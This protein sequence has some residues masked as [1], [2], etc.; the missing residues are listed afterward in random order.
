MRGH[1]M[2]SVQGSISLNTSSADECIA[3]LL[4]LRVD[5]PFVGSVFEVVVSVILFI[6]K[7]NG[8]LKKQQMF[9]VR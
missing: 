6:H 8:T 9:K 2:Q 3:G 5:V 4:F 1:T 7:F